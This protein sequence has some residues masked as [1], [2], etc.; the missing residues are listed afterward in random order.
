MERKEDPLRLLTSKPTREI[1]EFLDQHSYSQYKDLR[2]FVAIHT[3][4]SKLRNL[5]SY[6]L[7]E[8][9]LERLDIRR[10]WYELTD[11]GRKVLQFLKE[12][13]E[14][15]E[16]EKRE[17][18]FNA[19]SQVYAKEVLEFL[20]EKGRTRYKDMAAFVSVHTLNRRLHD[21]WACGLI[22]HHLERVP[23][24]KEWYEI[25]DKGREV[26]KHVRTLVEFMESQK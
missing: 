18:L 23:L 2:A 16:P 19:L 12:L 22:E 11:R 7:I 21:L 5:L 24:R 1:L 17:E 6:E 10:E 3:L 4:N 13:A 20:N 9:H 26:F 8:H 14:I 15:V 25:T